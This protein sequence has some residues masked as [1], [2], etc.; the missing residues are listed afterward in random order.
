MDVT[1]INSVL[2]GLLLVVAAP[3]AW[4]MLGRL[5]QGWLLEECATALDRAAALGLALR[6]TGFRARLVALGEVD[7]RPVRLEWRT[8][9]LGP[10][11]R[12]RQGDAAQPLPL[13]RSSAEVDAA[14]LGEAEPDRGGAQGVQPA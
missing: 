11:C 8:G 6:P 2:A 10:R 3:W 7:G 4:Y 5:Q 12:L 13:L 1:V 9:V 14:L